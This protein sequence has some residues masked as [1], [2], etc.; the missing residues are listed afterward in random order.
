[1]KRYSLTHLSDESLRREL[2][3]AAANE[4]QATAELLARIAE[5][6][7]RKLYLPAAYPSM[8]TY[9][10]GALHLSEDAAKK[11]IQVARVGRQYP[12]VLDALADGR[13][14]L[15]GLGILTPHF[16][17]ETVSELLAAATHKSK[18]EI[19][20]LVAERFPRPAVLATVRAVGLAGP[21]AGADEGAPAHPPGIEMTAPSVAEGAPAHLQA[22][23]R[24]SPLSAEASAVQFTRSS[25]A[26]ERFRYLQD[27]LGHQVA[28]RDLAEV[29]DRAVRELIAKMERVRFGVC[30]TPRTGRHRASP[31]SR[32]VPAHVKR[33][34]WQRDGG[35]CTFVGDTG[36]R[37]EAR[38]DV[39]FDHVREL[40][41]G[42]E[43]TVEGLQLRC[44]GH[45]QFTAECTFG[46]GFMRQKREVATAV[47]ASRERA[48][49]V[50]GTQG[51]EGHEP[52]RSDDDVFLALQTLGYGAAESR[53]A[54]AQC[55]D[56]RGAS[57][58]EKLRRA[59]AYF[60]Q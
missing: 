39:E 13:V 9:C 46:A 38:G 4:K 52:D 18:D 26:D 23:A 27:L 42:G 59:L 31:D 30:T 14:H 34:V 6:D 2:S 32:Y 43:T 53:R 51:A 17:P 47:R 7:E 50:R 25:E 20:R 44:R 37:C 36:H 41:R 29:Y 8:F 12:E 11:R 10:I 56:M 21:A 40:A 1:V 54:L 45:N 28:R 16:G 33:A 3:A 60:P 55:A 22:H 57:P 15:T 24:V 19:E 5:F 49:T 35:R 48:E 58:E